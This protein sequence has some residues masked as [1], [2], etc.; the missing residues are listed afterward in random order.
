[1]SHVGADDLAQSRFTSATYNLFTNNCN[2]FSDT[3]LTFLTGQR[4]PAHILSLPSEVLST[5]FGAQLRPFFDSM[6]SAVASDHGDE[7]FASAAAHCRA[8]VTGLRVAAAPVAPAGPPVSWSWSRLQAPPVAIVELAQSLTACSSSAVSESAR[9]LLEAPES[10]ES[11][12]AC[13]R[14]CLAAAQTACTEQLQ[15]AGV[16]AAVFEM[17]ALLVTPATLANGAGSTPVDAAELDKFFTS[18]DGCDAI[19]TDAAHVPIAEAVL[20]TLYGVIRT[21]PAGRALVPRSGSLAVLSRA[22]SSPNH[23]LADGAAAS[24]CVWGESMTS[25]TAAKAS[26]AGVDWSGLAC[27]LCF[28]VSAAVTSVEEHLRQVLLLRAVT[29]WIRAVEQ[30]RSLVRELELPGVLDAASSDVAGALPASG[31]SEVQAAER[32][33]LLTALKRE[34]AGF[35]DLR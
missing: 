13:L 2:N 3:L 33:L 21:A 17:V 25:Q 24:A 28:A 18:A 14:D 34:L 22:L 32:S 23:V 5:P 1:M 7:S 10:V 27:A 9:I 16:N 31:A 4:V 19:W 20:A 11:R 6:Q 29:G 12:R 26:A 15:G 30:L 8:A 35:V